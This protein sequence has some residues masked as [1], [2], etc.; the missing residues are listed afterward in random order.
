LRTDLVRRTILEKDDASLLEIQTS[1][2]SEEEVGSL[3]DDL[4]VGLSL[5]VEESGDVGDVDRFGLAK[6]RRDRTRQIEA[7]SS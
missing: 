7:R 5:R 3:D 4:E 6:K 1:L 2:L